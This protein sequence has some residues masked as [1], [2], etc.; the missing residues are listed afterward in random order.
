MHG[1]RCLSC[2]VLT[3][4]MLGLLVDV[5]AA[6][7]VIDVLYLMQV[8]GDCVLLAVRVESNSLPFG[9]RGCVACVHVFLHS[10]MA[11]YPSQFMTLCAFMAQNSKSMTSVVD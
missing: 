4:S 7:C 6:F 11:T 3:A 8:T 1:F 5:L 2:E 10:L 9:A